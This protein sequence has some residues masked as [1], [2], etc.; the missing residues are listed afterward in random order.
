RQ[1]ALVK[2]FRALV[3]AKPH[4]TGGYTG[5]ILLDGEHLLQEALLCDVPIEVA[6]FSERQVA[7]VLSPL[8]RMARDVRE[9]GGRPLIGSEP[10][11]AAMSPVQQPSGVVAIARARA[12]DVNVVFA[13]AVERVA[14][15]PLV[16]VLAGVQ[17]PG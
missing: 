5:E 4:G 10:V 2:R 8:G 11:L 6:A 14:P 1:N 12:I 15:L 13:A 16:L 7:N 17:D 3:R 9:R